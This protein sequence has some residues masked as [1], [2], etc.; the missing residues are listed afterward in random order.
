MFQLKKNRQNKICL[1][2][3]QKGAVLPIVLVSIFLFQISFFGAFRIYQNKMNTY[4]VLIN[5]YQ[6]QTLLMSTEKVLKE[7]YHLLGKNPPQ[8]IIYNI[9]KVEVTK[10]KMEKYE[11]TSILYNG[12][13]ETKEVDL[14]SL[15][16]KNDVLDTKTIVRVEQEVF[17][18]R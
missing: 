5:H 13:I 4:Q 9:G 8:R 18:R 3:K 7:E 1:L 12:F 2:E 16:D 17:K 6:S 15:L 10:K 14:P 11:L